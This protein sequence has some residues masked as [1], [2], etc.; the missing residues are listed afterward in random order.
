MAQIKASSITG[1]DSG[2]STADIIKASRRYGNHLGVE[3]GAGFTLLAAT[4]AQAWIEQ[5]RTLSGAAANVVDVYQMGTAGLIDRGDFEAIYGV[6]PNG[7]VLVR[8]DGHVAWRSVAAPTTEDALQS[9]LT[10][11]I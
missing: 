11:L 4:D 8:P 5:A 6:S 10:G 9:V 1:G 2:L 3:F 7:A